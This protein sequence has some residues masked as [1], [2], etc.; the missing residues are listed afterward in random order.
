MSK[1]ASRRR[2]KEGE[3]ERTQMWMC[4]G[5]LKKQT[6]DANSWNISKHWPLQKHPTESAFTS[7]VVS[8][9]KSGGWLWTICFVQA[10]FATPT[11]FGLW[12]LDTFQIWSF[13]SQLMR[14]AS[15]GADPV[16]RSNTDTV[17]M[18]NNKEIHFDYLLINNDPS[19]VKRLE[20]R[21]NSQIFP[22]STFSCRIAMNH[23]T[24]R[25]TQTAWKQYNHCTCSLVHGPCLAQ[26]RLHDI[27]T[28]RVLATMKMRQRPMEMQLELE[29]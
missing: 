18:G 11:V 10:Q 9:F 8:E 2:K 16:R 17:K 23:Q 24:N 29:R 21:M 6:H 5:W 1:K 28:P 7:F 13:D 27:G 19:S 3:E 15:D 4:K 25:K 14:R 12:V 26:R 22:P 20:R